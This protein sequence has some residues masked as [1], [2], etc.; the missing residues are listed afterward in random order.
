MLGSGIGAGL[1]I[2]GR[3][4]RGAAGL[5]GE[6]GH[7][8]V[9][10]DGAVCRCGNRGCL[11]TVAGERRARGAAPAARSA[12]D[13]TVRDADRARRRRATSAPPRLVNDAGRA[14]GRVLA[15]LCNALNPEAIIVGGELS[16]AATPLLDGIRESVDR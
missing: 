8:Q 3:V 4:H 13:L 1:V 16:E 7:V 2:D 11:E 14:I 5:A 9:R 10:T 15:D 6:L 12:R